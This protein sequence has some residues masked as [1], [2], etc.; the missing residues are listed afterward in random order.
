MDAVQGSMSHRFMLLGLFALTQLDLVRA[1]VSLD[2]VKNFCRRIGHSSVYKNGT[3]YINGGLETYVDFGADGQQDWSTITSG[4]NEN[5]ISV[6]M[7]ASWDW[8]TNVSI[9]QSARHESGS[10]AGMQWPVNVHDGSLFGGLESSSTLYMFGGTTSSFNQSFPYFEIPPTTQYGLWTYDMNADVWA[11]VDT[12]GSLDTIPS[13]GANAEAPDRG[14]A[15]Y[16]GGQIDG[17]TANTTQF[18]V[19]DTV[20]VG[21]MVVLDTTSNAIKNVTVDDAVKSNRQGAGLVYVDNFGDA[22]VLVLLG[23]ETQADGLI[24]MDEIWVFDVSSTDLSDNPSADKNKWYQQKATGNAPAARVDFCLVAAPAQDNSSSSIYLY[25]GTSNGTI[26]DDIYVLSLPSFTWVQVFTGQDARW[27]VTCHFIPPRQMITVGGGGK[28]SNISSDCDWEQKS[29]AVLDLSTIGWGSVFDAA[30]P[31]YDVP[32]DVVAAIGGG[33]AGNATKVEPEGGW[34]ESGLSQLF[35]IRKTATTAPPPQNSTIVTHSPTPI[36]T[37]AQDNKGSG[38]SG[39]AI[40]GI[41]IAVV[42]GVAIVCGAI[43]FWLRSRRQHRQNVGMEIPEKDSLPSYSTAASQNTPELGGTP[44]AAEMPAKIV[45]E[46]PKPD[47]HEPVEKDAGTVQGPHP[48]LRQNGP[49]EM[50]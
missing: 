23:G 18:L 4:I 28:S 16:V 24:P 3:L 17:G 11:A 46:A 38:L 22:G 44:Q 36:P 30:A 20:G 37:E 32:D 29:L 50:E 35:T 12:S 5:L 49:A 10:V 15:F 6:D 14:L 40:A 41:V 42:A 45:P 34:A 47:P 8:Q 7:T 43:F 25:G 13:W 31:R 33:P 26:F 1:G 2:P 21:G 27:S 9:S 39:G 19:D 48:S